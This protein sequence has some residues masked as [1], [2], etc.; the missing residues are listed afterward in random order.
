MIA[1]SFP[2]P[3][4]SPSVANTPRPGRLVLHFLHGKRLLWLRLLADAVV[5]QADFWIL[6]S[7]I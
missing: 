5:L 2:V 1:W 3:P 6:S 4:V 7:A